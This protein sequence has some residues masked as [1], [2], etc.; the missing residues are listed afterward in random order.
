MVA[1]LSPRGASVPEVMATWACPRVVRRVFRR[2]VEPA[3]PGGISGCP[4]R[5]PPLT[6]MGWQEA[7]STHCRT[8]PAFQYIR[9]S[10]RA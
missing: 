10:D 3:F 2:R 6:G 1:R 7:P 9:P 8:W 5:S 4:G